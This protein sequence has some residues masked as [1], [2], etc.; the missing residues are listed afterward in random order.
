M[1][2]PLT[3]PDTCLHLQKPWCKKARQDKALKLWEYIDIENVL[4]SRNVIY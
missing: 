3:A 4:I 1:T 2:F